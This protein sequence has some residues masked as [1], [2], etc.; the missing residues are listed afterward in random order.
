MNDTML[1]RPTGE[2]IDGRTVDLDRTFVFHS[3]STQGALNS[4]ST[5]AISGRPAPSTVPPTKEQP[6][7]VPWPLLSFPIRLHVFES[8]NR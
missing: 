7:D 6:R 4:L 8:N 2:A 5:A 3:W 1:K